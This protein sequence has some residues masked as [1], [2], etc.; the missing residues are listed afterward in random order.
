MKTADCT[1]SFSLYT[2][3]N[4][5]VQE[6]VNGC[7]T[8]VESAGVTQKEAMDVADYLK[9]AIVRSLYLSNTSAPFKAAPVDVHHD[10]CGGVEITGGEIEH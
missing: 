4:K 6:A 2:L 5:R 1:Y 3:G 10:G 7:L 8:A 9:N